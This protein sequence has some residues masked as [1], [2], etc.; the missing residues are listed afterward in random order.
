[1][2]KGLRLLGYGFALPYLRP[3]LLRGRARHR[4]ACRRR[5]GVIAWPARQMP[6][7]PGRGRRAAFPDAFFDR[8]LVVHGLEEAER[9]CARCCASFGG[10]WR[11]KENCCW[12]RPTAPACGRRWNGRPSAMAG[13]SPAANWKRCC[14]TRCSCPSTGDRALYAPPL[15]CRALIGTGAG[16]ERFGERL[17]PG[18]GRRASRRSD[19]IALR[20]GRARARRE[21]AC[22][23]GSIRRGPNNYGFLRSRKIAPCAS[24]L[25]P[26]ASGTHLARVS[27]FSFKAHGAFDHRRRT[28]APDR[29]NRRQVQRWMLGV[30]YQS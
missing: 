1:M 18:S 11:R 15:Q 5:M 26:Q 25:G 4:R 9:L 21:E 3:F 19:Q 29:R 28:A 22:R 2:S 14:A 30:S 8:I 17:L 16:W 12:W 13:H 23:R 10:C 20:P 7:R 6:H 24:R 27:P